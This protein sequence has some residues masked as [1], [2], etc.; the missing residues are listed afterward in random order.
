MN[1]PDDLMAALRERAKELH[2]L[3]EVEKA[4][5]ADGDKPCDVLGEVVKV[6][7]PGWKY[8][9]VCESRI[10]FDDET[11]TTPGFQETPWCLAAPIAVQGETV[12]DLTVCYLESR[13]TEDEGPFL[14]EEVRLIQSLADRLGHWVLFQKLE[15]MG[16]K[17]RELGTVEA[18]HGHPDWRVLVDL[19]R[20]T[21]E[22][23]F[24]RVSRK[25]L[26]HLCSIGLPEGQEM[27]REIDA[28]IDPILTSAGEVNQPGR[29]SPT[30]N[31][32]LV[33]GRPFELAASYISG[34][35]IVNRLQGWVQ[36]D[37]ASI[38]LKVLDNPRSTLIE[39]RDALRRFH[40]LARGT[41]LPASALKSVRVALS[42]RLLTEQL[43]FVQTAKDQVSVDFFRQVMDRIVMCED[44][45]GKLGGKAAGMLL[46][47][48]ILHNHGAKLSKSGTENHPAPVAA[49]GV[50]E[51]VSS[52]SDVLSSVKI[53]QTWYI[54]SDA[55]LD[56]ISYN[57][58]EDLLHQKY[59]SIDEV[60]RDYPNIIRLFKNSS[61][62][63]ELVKGLSAVLDE[64]QGV[65]V[66]IRSSSLLED[67]VG[68][69]FSGK[70]K[71]LFLPNQ[72]TKHECLEALLDAVA[73]VYASM[74][75]PDP[76]Q[77]RRERGVLEYDE[78]MGILIQEVVGR[79]IGRYFFPA[80][81]GVAF[82]RNE[83]RWSPRI[84]R[85]DGL[86]RLVPGLGTRAVDRTG[87]DYP[88][89]LVPGKPDLRVN[90]AIEEIV[91]YSP[92]Q[93]DLVNL[94]TN[95][96]ETMDLK[97]LLT[98]VGM[99]YPAFPQVFA[100]L[101]GGRL[102]RPVSNFFDPKSRPMVACFEGLR[103]N[104]DF[105][106]Q[107]RETLRVLEENLHCPVDV[108]F[109][110]DGENLFLLQCRP[111]S[112][113]DRAAPSPIPKDVSESDII[114]SAK[115]HISNCRIPEIKYIVYV[116]PTEYGKL[117]SQDQM[118]QVGRAVGELNKLLPKKQF[119]LMGPGRWGSRGDIKLGVS[120]TY[121]D[122]N[123][124]SL[125]IEIALKQGNYVPDVSF[126]TH[127]F[128]DLVESGIGYLPVYP[129][130]EGVDFNGLFLKRSD[131]LLAGLLP[132][133]AELADVVKVIDVPGVADGRVLHVLLNAD[134]DEALAYLAP[135]SGELAPSVPTKMGVVQPPVQFWRWRR[136]M[137]ERISA[138]LDRQKMGVKALYLFGS[139]KNATAG[140][141]SDIDLLIHVEDDP[142]KQKELMDWLD[143][144][145]RCLAEFNYQRTGYRTDGLL[146]VHL[147]TDA[148]IAS[149]SSFAVKIGAVT[150][151]AQALPPPPLPQGKGDD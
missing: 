124:T 65:P 98:E 144:W 114:F 97:D 77:Y 146:D 92:R 30:D 5:S 93:I 143:G 63:P 116:D 25:M 142:G 132:A 71:S 89:L 32:L 80:Y 1:K 119:I 78:Q 18:E 100:A 79:R 96:F 139:V 133:F 31:P 150:D 123:N 34:D 17:W 12:G 115:R 148:D 49:G 61:F 131:N 60:R 105:V 95:R 7:G 33:L 108:E 130:D 23:L 38:F 36:A 84:T 134:L 50:D 62:P 16:Q 122:I 106:V 37:K 68:S 70:Y 8:P 72:G 48:Q 135:P 101:E 127:F 2:C 15:N 83:F 35:E 140:P 88:V 145:S 81:A 128:Q 117:S 73:E 56:F 39:L 64:F 76:I 24:V 9:E 90:V 11:Y 110:H 42:Q 99:N 10:R 59:R 47:H 14:K 54:A 151:A 86:V 26:N 27:L 107:I 29:R 3:Y 45:H 4:L 120:I 109:A 67:R 118:K 121:A 19:L 94:E 57:D 69:A 103:G 113:S 104:S 141:A 74:F 85:E 82:S 46:A 126:G 13:P 40:Q 87:D 41:G 51:S 138:E 102:V 112:Q 147:V 6:I 28:D 125:L 55:I 66:I 149:R 136:Q 22:A 75:G 44:S 58:L 137:A 53:P 111:Q 129:D 52:E 43:D 20:E 91:R 21:D